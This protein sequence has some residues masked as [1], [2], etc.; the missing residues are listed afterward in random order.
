MSLAIEKSP[1]FHADVTK[2]L[3]WYSD[4]AGEELAGRFFNAVDQTFSN[5]AR[6]S[7]LGRVRRFRNP[8]LPGLCSFQVEASFNRF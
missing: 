3:G 6:Q 5:F 1:L 7:D 2:P 8:L 4:E